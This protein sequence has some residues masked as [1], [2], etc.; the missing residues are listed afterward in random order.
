M[1][2]RLHKILR[3]FSLM[4]VLSAGIAALAQTSAPA[5]KSS[6]D[7][8]TLSNESANFEHARQVADAVLK[9]SEFRQ[10]Q[11]DTWWEKKKQQLS[12]VLTRAVARVAKAG[13]T[14]PWMAKALEWTLFLGAALGLLLFL[15]RELR[16]QRAH[17]SLSDGAVKAEAWT[18]EADDWS[19]RAE[20]YAEKAEWREAVHCLYWAAI[21]LLESRKAWR[22][23]PTRT[24]RE[25]VRLL[26]AGSAQQEALRGLTQVFERSWYGL[27]E[28]D[29]EQYA[30]ARVLYDSLKTASASAQ[31]ITAEVR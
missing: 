30:K 3:A 27:R 6:A 16:R 13:R 23:N 9:G 14:V 28:V 11:E 26:K 21:V 29:S 12:N 2:R 5:T 15:L 1:S 22:H 18:R 25:Y 4:V 17:V 31:Q 19:Q 7:A 24:P 8:T 10:Q 20:R